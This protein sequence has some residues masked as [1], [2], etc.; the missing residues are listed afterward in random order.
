M[1]QD[2]LGFDIGGTKCAVVLGRTTAEGVEI[3]D[4][5]MFATEGLDE[6]LKWL[7]AGAKELIRR[8]GAE[9]AALG[10]SCG[11]PLDSARGV[12]L[13]PPNLPGWDA[14]PITDHFSRA[15]GIPAWL[16]NDANAGALA[17]WRWGAGRG[18]RHL[19]FLT[20]GTGF[21]AGLILNGQLY[22]GATGYAG[23][24]GHVRLERF[25]LA[26]YGKHGSVEGFLG[27][28]SI[29]RMGQEVV[30]WRWQR[31]ETVALCPKPVNLHTLTAK[32]IF[33][34]ARAGEPVALEVVET[35]GRQLG[36][37]LA[38]LLDLF[39]P[40]VIVIGSNF[41]RAGDLLLPFVERALREEALPQTITACRLLPAALGESLGDYAALSVAA[42]AL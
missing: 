1:A 11:G 7:E 2:L 12:I 10:I 29:A 19:V 40:E 14:V 38:I 8:H 20:F 13:G 23:E 32:A 4:R 24:I 39:N 5:R 3:C 26:A 6:T 17:E 9:P 27:G 35:V 37:A 42:S 36:R 30:R 21:G 16:Q 33:D 41:V 28:H 34:A 15:L 18:A 31:G 25:G 22:E